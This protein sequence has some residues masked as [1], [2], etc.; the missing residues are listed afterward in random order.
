MTTVAL[1]RDNGLAALP[2]DL[3]GEA[4]A[5]RFTVAVR[6]T[7]GLLGW[8]PQCHA[9]TVLIKPN[10]VRTFEGKPGN[11]TDPRV[12]LGLVR[13]LQ[14]FAPARVLIGENPGC[15]V[16]SACGFRDSG[17]EQ[18]AALTGAELVPFDTVPCREAET[19]G[20]LLLERAKVPAPWLDA[21][22]VINLP[23]MKTH[24]HAGVSLGIKNLHGILVDADRYF[25]HRVDV[26]QKMVDLL[27]IR[28]PDL[29]LV[30]GVLAM[31]GQSPF[32]GREKEMDL[33]VAGCDPVA[34]DAV[35]CSAMGFRPEEI[36]IIR[37]ASTQGLGEMD[38]ERIE[39]LGTPLEEATAPFR[40]GIISSAGVYEGITAIEL[41]ACDGCLSS[42]R[43]SLDRL[44]YEGR[45]E[46]L[47]PLTVITG[48]PCRNL[49]ALLR[50]T[51]PS[52]TWFMGDCAAPLVYDQSSRRAR[53]GFVPGC[54]PHSFDLYKKI[55]GEDR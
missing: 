29:T 36:G 9:R 22:L 52:R 18:I 17:C 38:L 7:L 14:S 43:H 50:E 6:A 47:A 13:V 37:L 46:E 32:F 55:V 26:H 28:R 1:H 35:A 20:G 51:D 34:V 19:G 8:G 48:A 31:E 12:L 15:G 16:S 4:T 30:D 3:D 39:V 49:P 45:I 11:T 25:H 2:F 27:M 53:G 33:L 10:L 44:H 42:V 24:L 40:R 23:K 5:E 54:A 21:D 41:G